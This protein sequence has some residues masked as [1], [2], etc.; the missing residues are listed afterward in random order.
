MDA[1]IGI[2][3]VSPLQSAECGRR[4]KPFERYL[5]YNAGKHGIYTFQERGNLTPS[6]VLGY[7]NGSFQHYESVCVK[8]T[9]GGDRKCL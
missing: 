1:P 6:D 4:S 2:C 5:G 7:L 3:T 8:T 9:F